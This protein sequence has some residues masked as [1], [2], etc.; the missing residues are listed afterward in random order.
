MSPQ[1]RRVVLMLSIIGS[2]IGN[3]KISQSL[4]INGYKKRIL[5]I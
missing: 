5:K 1:Q 2:I 3:N 4:G